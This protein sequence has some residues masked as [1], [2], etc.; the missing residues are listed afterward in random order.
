VPYIY[1]GNLKWFFKPN[2]DLEVYVNSFFGADGISMGE[3]FEA[4]EIDMRDEFYDRNLHA[5]AVTGLNVLPTNRSFI[6]FFAGYEF[7]SQKNDGTYTEEGEMTYSDEF[8]NYFNDNNDE[9]GETFYGYP[10][11][12][13]AAG[14]SFNVDYDNEWEE[15]Y[16]LNSMQSRLDADIQLTDK[17]VFSTGGGIIYDNIYYRELDENWFKDS[18]SSEVTYDMKLD[19]FNQFNSSAYVNMN[20]TPV[21]NKLEIDTGVRVDHNFSLFEDDLINSYPA[22]NPRFYIAYTPVRNRPHL[23]YFTISLGTGLYSKMPDYYR[24]LANNAAVESFDINPEK[25]LTNVLGF[26]WMFPVG[27]KLK[28]EGYYKFYYDRFYAMEY[29]DDDVV[30]YN[31]H[32]DGIGHAGGFD[33]ILKR[34]ISRY[35]DGSLSYSFVYA[36]Y[37]NPETDGSEYNINGEPLGKW[38]YPYF[39]RFHGF[40]LNLNIKPTDFFTISIL[41]GIHSGLL[42][43]AQSEP[44]IYGYVDDNNTPLE[45]YRNETSYSEERTGVS[46]PLDIRLSYHNYFKSGKIKFETYF[47]MENILSLFYTPDKGEHLNRYSGEMEESGSAAYEVFMPTFGFK[48]SY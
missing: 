33:V 5:I 2:D 31:F 42:K 20:F 19:G 48:L 6:H 26:E 4:D 37:K 44:E 24:L 16:V 35:I 36:Q 3:D 15:K 9:P 38:Y 13:I 27:L 7:Y 47:A 11:N 29:L 40:N 46:L 43:S 18:F 8:V 21:Y 12:Y 28:L 23:E 45:L 30:K 1:D 22:V 17:M 32:S 39:H 14:D 34:K 41:F 10:D 25:C